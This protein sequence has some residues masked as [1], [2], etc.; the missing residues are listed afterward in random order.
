[1]RANQKKNVID[2]KILNRL[3][4]F[5]ISKKAEVLDFVEYLAIKNQRDSG[6]PIYS[7]SEGLVKEKRIQKMS[8]REIKAIVHDV[9]GVNG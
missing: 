4:N 5:S 3:Q 9:R 8:L 6:T 1:M 7:Y 2:E